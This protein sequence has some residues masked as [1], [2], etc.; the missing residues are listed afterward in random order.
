[1][2]VRFFYGRVLGARVILRAMRRLFLTSLLLLTAGCSGKDDVSVPPADAG[3]DVA[4]TAPPE[5][6]DAGP[7]KLTAG[8]SEL[9]FTVG[10]R[11]RSYV[12]VV[13]D[14]IKDKTLPLVVAMHERNERNAN[15]ISST[16]KLEALAKEKG[17][18]LAAPQGIPQGLTIGETAMTVAWD[19]YRTKEQGNIDLPFLETLISTIVASGSIDT[20]KIVVYGYGDGAFMSFRYGIEK[21]DEVSCAAV[22]AGGNPLDAK[23]IATATKKIPFAIQIGKEDPA[24]ANATQAKTDLEKAG[25]SVD[26]KDVSNAGRTPPP[27]DPAAPLDN[28]LGK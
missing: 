23:L 10:G 8:K 6:V 24:Y 15:F 11:A 14:A 27:G 25:F 28:C 26:F 13:P 5:P 2:Q 19:A 7:Q 1:M 3:P 12:L 22:L 18:V 21:S 17:F 16:T 20:K 4:D 9:S